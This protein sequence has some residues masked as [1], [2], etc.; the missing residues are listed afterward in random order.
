MSKS[1]KISE[2]LHH[3][4]DRLRAEIGVKWK[5]LTEA[6]LWEAIKNGPEAVWKVIQ[7]YESKP[8]E[9][10]QAASTKKASA[11][12]SKSRSRNAS[13]AGTHHTAR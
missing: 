6:I 7:R 11:P 5:E 3:E 4:L 12:R 8:P 1:L 2:E 9:E 10:P 13:G